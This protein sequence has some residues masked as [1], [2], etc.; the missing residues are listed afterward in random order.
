M[1]M[2]DYLMELPPDDC[3]SLLASSMLGRLGVIV[4]GQP[5]IFPVNYV[6]DQVTDSVAFSTSP[7]TKLYVALNSPSVAFEVDNVDPDGEG[8]WSVLVVGKAQVIT[9]SEDVA[10]MASERCVRWGAGE[11]LTWV[12]IAPS[13]VTG[14]RIDGTRSPTH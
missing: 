5:E 8:G 9:D 11:S 3:A 2:R 13:K 6:Y 14:R 7:G 4:D 12:R 1:S 10:R